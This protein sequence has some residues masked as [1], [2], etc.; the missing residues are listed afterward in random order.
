ML[1]Q[2]SCDDG[3]FAPDGVKIV[4]LE[5]VIDETRNIDQLC[6]FTSENFKV[7]VSSNGNDG[8]FPGEAAQDP[9]RGNEQKYAGNGRDSESLPVRI[10]AIFPQPLVFLL[11][12][13]R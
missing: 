3:I 9:A 4:I 2:A 1:Q 13:G 11:R 10:H 12:H 7:V 6:Q 5:A 8:A